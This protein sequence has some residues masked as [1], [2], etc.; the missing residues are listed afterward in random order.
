MYTHLPRR[1]DYS[2]NP[3][4]NQTILWLLHQ[5]LIPLPI[6]PY[7]SPLKGANFNAAKPGH[8]PKPKF[9]GKNPSWLT[10]WGKP[11]LIRHG[12][13]KAKPP[14]VD[15]MK[16]WFAHPDTGIATAAGGQNVVWI[17]IDAKL[18]GSVKDCGVQVQQWL[19]QYDLMPT[20]VERTQG[21]GWHIAIRC[22]E[23]PAFLQFRFSAGGSRAGE[24]LKESHAVVLAPTVGQLGQY[25]CIERSD[26]KSVGRVED[27]GI[28]AIAMPK[29]EAV[30]AIELSSA[31]VSRRTLKPGVRHRVVLLHNLLSQRVLEQLDQLEAADEGERSDVL[32]LVAREAIGWQNWM[33]RH[34]YG[35]PSPDALSFVAWCGEQLGFDSD[36]IERVWSS[37]S[38]GVPISESVPAIHFYGGDAACRRKLLQRW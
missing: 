2:P 9:T 28:V 18:F 37:H 35:V 13:H 24:I 20:Y 32:V 31:I 30:G 3:A 6:A 17:D 8:P 10:A 33:Q 26:P 36:R 29:D 4:V 38:Y 16:R 11:I 7:Q 27:L 23:I 34:G 14:V 21:G 25:R 19:G 5:G 15:V 1:Q 22:K 12:E